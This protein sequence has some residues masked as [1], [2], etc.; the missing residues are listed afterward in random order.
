MRKSI[1][2]SGKAVNTNCSQNRYFICFFWNLMSCKKTKKNKQTHTQRLPV[3][4]SKK[5]IR[6]GWVR[7]WICAVIHVSHSAPLPR[8]VQ[9]STLPTLF[10]V[11]SIKKNNNTCHDIKGWVWEYNTSIHI[12]HLH[13]PGLLILQRSAFLLKWES[14]SFT[15]YISYFC[16][17][18]FF[19]PFWES[20]EQ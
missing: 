12:T 6:S 14:S 13:L 9:S 11:L 7:N 8:K 5:R 20:Q 17:L 3:L 1:H 19:Y 4:I 15:E 16:P 10:P 18:F 2:I